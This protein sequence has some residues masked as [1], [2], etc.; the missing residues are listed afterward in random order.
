MSRT[1]P[2]ELYVELTQAFNQQAWLQ[3]RDLA[4]RWFATLPP[5]PSVC[6][7]AGVACLELEQFTPAIEYLRQATSIEHTRADFAVQFAKALSLARDDERAGEAADRARTLSKGNA[8]LLD[9]LGVIY[10]RAGN[11]AS[12][13]NAFREAAILAPRH[14]AFR[15]NLAMSEISAGHLDAAESELEACIALE[16]RYWIG[17]LKLAHLRRQTTSHNHVSRLEALLRQCG[18]N[19]GDSVGGMCLHMALAK[20][21][22]DLE[23]YDDAFEHLVQGKAAGAVPNDYSISDDHALFDAITKA[24]AIPAPEAGGYLSDEPIFVLGMPRSGTT[25][26]ERIVSSHPDVWSAGELLNFALC[27]KRLSGCR[28]AALLDAAT[29]KAAS[30]GDLHE[31]GEAYI[32]STRPGTGKTPKFIDK[33]PYNFLYLGH[34]ANALPN[35]TILWV[36]RNPL[37]TCLSNFRQLFAPN[38]PFSGYSFDLLDV[39][40][41]YVLFHRL[42]EHWQRILPG[43]ILEVSYEALVNSQHDVTQGILDFCGLPWN[44]ACLHFERNPSPVA[45]ASAAQV[46]SPIHKNALHRWKH[47]ERQLAPLRD[48]LEKSGVLD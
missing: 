6:Y 5:H 8:A 25:L 43:R 7:M 3:T 29:V 22:E 20:E 18:P 44:D 41:Y 31:L 35:A 21:L 36:R 17:H 28:T 30:T 26:V 38:S 11:H 10:T 47:Y 37:D 48:L 39:G 42:M 16:P 32:A 1:R 2:P 40:R 33:L 13:A 23:R 24:F 45:T 4:A 34:I 27:F 15:Y 12:A 19:R 9:T 46:R 14:A